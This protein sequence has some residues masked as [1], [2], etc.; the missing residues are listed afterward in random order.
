MNIKVKNEYGFVLAVIPIKVGERATIEV[1]DVGKSVQNAL[2]TT[3]LHCKDG[4]TEYVY[5]ISIDRIY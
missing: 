5:S 2:V 1:S 3:T 4:D